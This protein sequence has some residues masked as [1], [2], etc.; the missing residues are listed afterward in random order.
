MNKKTILSILCL[1]IIF[2]L[3]YTL[4]VVIG[5]TLR[6]SNNEGA[7]EPTHATQTSTAEQK[8]KQNAIAETQAA[9]ELNT[10]TTQSVTECATTTAEKPT[11]PTV[12]S[13]V[14]EG[15]QPIQLTFLLQE[16]N[17]S[18]EELNQLGCSQIITVSSAGNTAEISMFSKD[19]TGLWSSCNLDAP[20]YVGSEG[21]SGQS[22]EG[23][24][25][26][27]AGLFAIGQAFY[28]YN[29]P[30]TGLPSFQVTNDTYWVD[31]PDSVYYNQRVE[32]TTNK[33]W[34]SAEHMIDYVSYKY[35]C[36]IEFN[37]NNTEKGKGS[38]IFFHC[39]DSPTAGCVAVSEDMMLSYL[40]RLDATQ[41]PYILIM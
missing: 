41:K 36:V 10:P 27:P 16:G 26:T 20:G 31:D 19:S 22:Y 2:L 39:G 9:S 32:G 33:D 37:T 15:Q 3:A 34:N 21:V 13:T 30:S 6:K 29:K 1:V 14:N 4:T 18:Y 7:T 25:Q 24:Y 23:S 12:S 5:W 40:G 8:P 17:T 35:G 11:Q 28:I 38:A